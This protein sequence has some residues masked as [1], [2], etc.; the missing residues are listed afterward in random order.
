MINFLLFMVCFE[1]VV[2]IHLL[3]M[4]GRIHKMCLYLR[5]CTDALRAGMENVGHSL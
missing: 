2:I 5:D 1:F 4:I 3:M